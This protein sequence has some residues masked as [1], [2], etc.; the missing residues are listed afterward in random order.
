M[1]PA[2]SRPL[3][4]FVFRV[5]LVLR[6]AGLE[7]RFGAVVFL[8]EVRRCAIYVS[9]EFQYGKECFL[10]HLY[11]ADLFHTFFPFFLLLEQF[12]FAAY[13]ASVTLCCNVFA[14]SLYRFTCYN[15]GS[16]GSLY[17]HVELRGIS[18]LS[19]SHILRPSV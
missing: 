12:T 9:V 16:D 15:L 8:P 17:C 7:A 3:S 5:L 1:P 4:V 18:S 6:F 10:W 11:R 14:Y 13:I 19:F 2:I